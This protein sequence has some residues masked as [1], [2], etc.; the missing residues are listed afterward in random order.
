MTGNPNQQDILKTPDSLA[1]LFDQDD[2]PGNLRTLRTSHVAHGDIAVPVQLQPPGTRLER[3][4][5]RQAECM[6]LGFVVAA[7]TADQGG[8]FRADA[9]RRDEDDTDPDLARIGQRGTVKPALPVREIVY[10]LAPCGPASEQA[11]N[12]E[13][14]PRRKPV[15]ALDD[16]QRGAPFHDVRKKGGQPL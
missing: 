11:G 5:Q 2:Q 3:D 16:L 6:Q 4:F 14:I 15:E 1:G 8:F 13:A 12:D 7:G 10:R 9:R